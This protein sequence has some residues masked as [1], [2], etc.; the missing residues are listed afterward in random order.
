MTAVFRNRA[1]RRNEDVAVLHLPEWR[2]ANPYLDNLADALRS[3]GVRVLFPSDLSRPVFSRRS[4][5]SV[6][7]V[8]LHWP[9]VYLE[10]SSRLGI[11]LRAFRLVLF[12]EWSRR[13]GVGLVWTAHNLGAHEPRWPVVQLWTHGYIARRAACIV[14]HYPAAGE[15]LGEW[16]G[17]EGMAIEVIDHPAFPTPNQPTSLSTSRRRLGL[18]QDAPVVLY[19][20]S[21]RRYKNTVRLMDAFR[22]SAPGNARLILAGWVSDSSLEKEIERI[23]SDDDRIRTML[24]FI[25]EDQVPD[26]MAAA[27]VV[28]VPHTS[29][30]TRGSAV[31]AM[32]YGKAVIGSNC[33]HLRYLLG[34][35]QS[36]LL[37]NPEDIEDMARVISL[38]LADSQRL[39]TVGA[40]NRQRILKTSWDDA[41]RQLS[42]I[43]KTILNRS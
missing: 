38:A 43:Y 28:A 33:P 20:G 40:R 30:L 36:D 7:L 14:V 5:R 32:S 22:L 11:L 1:P 8:H 18:D 6:D 9:E 17:V 21:I 34:S 13:T 15:L 3:R 27:D 29:G 2:E 41:G 19:L 37:F 31:L 25:P 24:Q 16:L 12:L 35:D 39:A 4:I 23:A 42:R 10:A 26:L